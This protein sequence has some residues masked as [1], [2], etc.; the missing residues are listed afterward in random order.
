MTDEELLEA[1]RTTVY[2]ILREGQPS[3]PVRIG[4]KHPELG[5]VWAFLTAYN[6][7]HERPLDAENLAAQAQ[8]Q[9]SIEALGLVAERAEGRGVDGFREPMFFVRGLPRE[10][11]ERLGKAFRQWGIVVAGEGAEAELVL[12]PRA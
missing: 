2:A 12:L 1:Y 9:Q 10:E 6:P 3:K 8:L 7:G 5:D 4:E 11:A